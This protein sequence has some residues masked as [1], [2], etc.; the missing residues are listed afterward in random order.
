MAP[1]KQSTKSEGR[2][3]DIPKA[4][5]DAKIKKNTSARK[6][7]SAKEHKSP[8]K[9]VKVAG[10]P[11]KRALIQWRREDPLLVM[12]LWTQW[13]CAK[14]HNKLPWDEIIPQCFTGVTPTAFTQ[15]LARER[16][17][18]LKAGWCV[19]PLPSQ[20][21]SLKEDKD[22]RGYI[23][24]PTPQNEDALKTNAAGDG[25]SDEG[26]IDDAIAEDQEDEIES[27][28]DETLN[29]EGESSN[30]PI[31][32]ASH[33]APSQLGHHLH[34]N[35]AQLMNHIHE[36]ALVQQNG[37]G[38]PILQAQQISQALEHADD[39]IQLQQQPYHQTQYPNQHSQMQQTEQE[40]QVLQSH[41]QSQHHTGGNNIHL[42]EQELQAWKNE[43]PENEARAYVE[44]LAP[45][46]FHLSQMPDNPND[47]SYPMSGIHRMVPVYSS[48]GYTTFATPLNLNLY[49]NL[50]G[51]NGQEAGIPTQ[52]FE[53]NPRMNLHSG[54]PSLNVSPTGGSHRQDAVNDHA[55]AVDSTPNGDNEGFGLG[56]VNLAAF[57]TNVFY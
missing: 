10:R 43:A 56:E 47:V 5:N 48:N 50:N 44:G 23:N 38:L 45:E 32:Q 49:G 39:D 18:V 36:H 29:K 41:L 30:D 21:K 37:Q 34:N 19:P 28:Y 24:A 17:R 6:N 33:Q 26:E 9:G 35:E 52:P 25:D 11:K 13:W 8:K 51:L 57:D 16:K 3:P 55:T 4:N 1:Y 40:W 27:D 14:K 22:I 15:F 46:A 7:T 54:T 53:N 2:L 12:T 31:H 42:S 20:A